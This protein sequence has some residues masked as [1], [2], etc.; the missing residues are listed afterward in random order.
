MVRRARSRISRTCSGRRARRS[1]R[2]RKPSGVEDR[3]TA[4]AS[5][6]HR[7]NKQ[8]RKWRSSPKKRDGG[9]D[10]MSQPL[11]RH[12]L[13]ISTEGIVMGSWLGL[14]RRANSP[15]HRMT[16]MRRCKINVREL[17][18]IC[19]RLG[20]VYRLAIGSFVAFWTLHV[21]I[22]GPSHLL[23]HFAVPAVSHFRRPICI[24]QELSSEDCLEAKA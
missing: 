17:T 22:H 12:D 11:A 13:N 9:N 16:R 19:R 2:R 21:D 8:K 6:S 5:K 10:R 4:S 7:H 3:W 24:F 14:D 20:C 23:L 15:S 1:R 18:C